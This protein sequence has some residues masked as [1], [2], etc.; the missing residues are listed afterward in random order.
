MSASNQFTNVVEL[1]RHRTQDFPD[2]YLYYFSD[3]GL[4]KNNRAYTYAELEKKII[5]TA[6]LI[7]EYTS[8]GDRVLMIFAPGL[9]YM[10]AFWACLYAGVL[11]VPAYPPFNK[12]TVEKIQAILENAQ[13]VAILSNTNI[14]SSIKRLGLLK[15]M[16]DNGLI[17][18][19]LQQ[20]ASKTNDLL[21]WD[22]KHFHWLDIN[23]INGFSGQW[24]PINTKL[25]DLA[26]L[27]YTS[28]STAMPKGVMVSHANILSNVELIH[29]AIGKTSGERMVS[30][31]PPYHDMGLISSLF[32][33]VYCRY[34]VMMMSPISFLR[35]PS[36]W[37]KAISE[38]KG[39]ISGGPNFSYELCEKKI[40]EKDLESGF[41]LS[42][43]RV[44]FNGA[45][46]IRHSTLENFAKKFSPFGFKKKAYYPLYGLAES[47]VFVSGEKG[48]KAAAPCYLFAEKESLKGNKIT[49]A[50]T[51]EDKQVLVGCGKPKVPLVIVS[52]SPRR[53]VCE[54]GEIGEIWISGS[55]ITKGYWG[56]EQETKECYFAR[57]EEDP[58]DYLRTGDLG[59]LLNG[60][61][62]ITGRIKDLIIINGK[63]YYPHDIELIVEGSDK[64]IRLGCTAVFAVNG[65]DKEEVAVVT[66]L[67]L[68]NAA[69]YEEIAQKIYEQIHLNFSIP[70]QVITFIPPKTIP[71]TTSGKLRRGY[72][73]AALEANELDVLFKWSPKGVL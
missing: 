66:E 60:N 49:I 53:R 39:S 24:K 71:K 33:P 42:H 16:A 1:F 4:Q 50:K 41:D 51:E 17:K 61:L 43:W 31:L 30:W 38:F 72:I 22:F 55:S 5:T 11:A 68:N 14:I 28:G 67:K 20:F 52:E 62:Y 34:A 7:Q 13:P 15:K 48:N 27:Q 47:T 12:N 2:S 73:R 64:A 35:D 32:F 70:V 63:N 25:D 58:L 54:E 69:T 45:E 8:P 19:L 36:L 3:T 10:I 26:Y 21:A 44:A 18:K 65:N 57:L 29:Q 40:N 46:P 59:L 9:D 6:A 37:L 56:K 23:Q